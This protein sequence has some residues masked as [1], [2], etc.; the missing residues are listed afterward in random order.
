MGAGFG[1]C[2]GSLPACVIIL[3]LGGIILKYKGINDFNK[4][5]K[6]NKEYHINTTIQEDIN[7]AKSIILTKNINDIIDYLNQ[8]HGIIS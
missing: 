5:V 2:P 4:F 8:M 7:Y 6:M 1:I 3:V